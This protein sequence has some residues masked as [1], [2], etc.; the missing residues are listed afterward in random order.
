MLM[1]SNMFDVLTWQF[2]EPTTKWMLR[3]KFL[4]SHT[5]RVRV[6]SYSSCRTPNQNDQIKLE[7]RGKPIIQKCFSLVYFWH[8]IY[9]IC[10][11]KSHIFVASMLAA[12]QGWT[13]HM[14]LE[15]EYWLYFLLI[16][17]PFVTKAYG[18]LSTSTVTLYWIIG[19][20]T[21]ISSLRY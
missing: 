16:W 18:L 4:N 13:I 20:E 7:G 10:V 12:R 8:C 14:I 15:V 5:Y 3:S 2:S 19:I 11:N 1:L 9:L 17:S 21:S 6:I